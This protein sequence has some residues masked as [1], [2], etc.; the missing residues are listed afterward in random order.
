[1]TKL[2]DAQAAGTRESNKCVLIL[3]EGDSAKTLAVSGL[4]DV[5]R[6]YLGVFPLRSKLLNIQ[7]AS[8]SVVAA[9]A[10]VQNLIKIL[11]LKKR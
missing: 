3:T 5:G 8:G 9:N 10:E 11:G 4:S 6:K 1:F 2:D 7:Q